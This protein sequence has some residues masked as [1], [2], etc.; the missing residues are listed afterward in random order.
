[1]ENRVAGIHKVGGNP[2]LKLKTAKQED[3]SYALKL[4]SICYVL[5]CI[6]FLHVSFLRCFIK[7]H[8]G[9]QVTVK[10]SDTFT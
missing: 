3:H 8:D 4:V 9:N 7:T 5:L 1:M 10:E 2:S 6:S